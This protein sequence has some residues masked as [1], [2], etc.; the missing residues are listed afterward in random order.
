ME[1]NSSS[2]YAIEGE[3]PRRAVSF[4]DE[5]ER[6][7]FEPYWKQFC[8]FRG[9]L[10]KDELARARDFALLMKD[11]DGVHTFYIVRKTQLLRTRA[12]KP[13]HSNSKCLLV[14]RTQD[15]CRPDCIRAH[16]AEPLADATNLL[17][18]PALEEMFVHSRTTGVSR[19]SIRDIEPTAGLYFTARLLQDGVI[20]TCQ[21]WICEYFVKGSCR[22]GDRCLFIH[23]RPTAESSQAI[24]DM[25]EATTP[26][27]DALRRDMEANVDVRYFVEHDLDALGIRTVGDVQVLSNNAFESLVRSAEPSKKVFW[28]LVGQLRIFPENMVTDMAVEMFPGAVGK[29]FEVPQSVVTIKQL[30]EM[31]AKQFYALSVPPGL[32]DILERIRA[33]SDAATDHPM[34]SSISLREHQG[35]SFYAV[36]VKLVCEFRKR[37]AHKSWRKQDATRPIVTSLI[38]FVDAERCNCRHVPGGQRTQ[39]NTPMIGAAVTNSPMK[40]PLGARSGSEGGTAASASDTNSPAMAAAGPADFGGA[41]RT[42]PAESWCTC[43]RQFE[44]AVNYEL[45]TPSGSRCS[46]QNCLGRL[47]SMGLPTDSIREVFVHGDT[48]NGEDPN[49]LFPCGVCENMFRRVSKDVMKKHGGDVMLYMFDAYDNPKK[50]VTIPISEI[51]LRAGSVFRRFVEED[52]KDE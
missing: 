22:N 8:F 3:P 20:A 43:E 18:P 24:A 49:P 26:L 31:K 48:H 47:A 1:A 38:T 35:D 16:L 42:Y 5:N 9:T 14:C 33:R 2:V 39:L 7:V 23:A 40:Q 25:L 21:P 28:N 36:M 30:V 27:T 51:S 32:M 4:A 12:M 34:Y 19:V 10:P 6:G 45:S 11:V 50:L 44:L 13:T 46:E 15:R 52:L 41:G 37:N 17:Q 29:N